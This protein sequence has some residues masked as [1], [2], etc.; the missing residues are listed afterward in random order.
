M[1]LNKEKYTFGVKAGKLLGFYLTE[2]GIEANPDKCRAVLEME[3]P[4]VKNIS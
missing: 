1:C 2:R 4:S 3:P